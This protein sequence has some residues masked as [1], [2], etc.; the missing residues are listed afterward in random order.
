M[1]ISKIEKVKLIADKNGKLWGNEVIGLCIESSYYKDINMV[2]ELNNAGL[3]FTKKRS[4][5]CETFFY[6]ID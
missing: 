4:T 1:E 6:M 2:V 3:S 5:D